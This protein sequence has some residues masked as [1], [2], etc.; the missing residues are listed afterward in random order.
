M[1]TQ[2]QN[3]TIAHKI[4]N[5]TTT[6]KTPQKS[7]DQDIKKNTP[8][9]KENMNQTQIINM[10]MVENEYRARIP[11][12]IETKGKLLDEELS[13]YSATEDPTSDGSYSL[14]VPDRVVTAA[15]K[16]YHYELESTT[17]ESFSESSSVQDDEN[18]EED[19]D[20]RSRTTAEYMNI[21][22]MEHINYLQ[23]RNEQLVE[24]N[25]SLSNEV[26]QMHTFLDTALKH[27]MSLE[28]TVERLQGKGE[29]NIELSRRSSKRLSNKASKGS[30][31]PLL[32]TTQKMT[33]PAMRQG[34]SK[35][36]TMTQTNRWFAGLLQKLPAVP[37]AQQ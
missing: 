24:S 15:K 23:E 25:Q 37:A 19:D 12:F 7:N 5:K 13:F 10:E 28:S 27:I 16:Q 2:N 20:N 33:L 32:K 1:T 34:T 4:R 3:E 9:T 30:A 11:S 8:N 6:R 14:D 18:D 29:V 21:A 17:G 35:K 22:L 31:E 36:Q 26:S